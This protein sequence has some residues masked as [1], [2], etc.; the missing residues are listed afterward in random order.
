M[1]A[2]P[3]S[4]PSFVDLIG[5]MTLA[6]NQHTLR[7]NIVHGEVTA[8]ATKIGTGAST[9]ATGEVLAATGTGTSAWGKVALAS[10]VSGTLPVANGGTGATT[11]T[12]SGAVVLAAG[13]TISAANLTS[14]PV[15]TTPTIASFANAN[16]S[17]TNS[18][19]GGTLNA[20]NALQA[21]TVDFANL[22]STIFSGELQ[23]FTNSAS[24][25]GVGY[26]IDLGGI[27]LMWGQTTNN[28]GNTGGGSAGAVAFPAFFTTVQAGFA[29]VGPNNTTNN[30][31]VLFGG[32]GLTTTGVQLNVWSAST[33]S[34]EPVN[35]LVIGT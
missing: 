25:G 21:G 20:A 34:G 31:S 5:S 30:Q 24:A 15:I 18:A 1:S 33:T 16:H 10:M 14:S 32:G 7:H 2:F 3:T 19:G 8:I 23:S 6:A 4:I 11:S 9:P 12:G 13:P 22:L 35:W 26:Y 17:H 27:K 29:T 28:I